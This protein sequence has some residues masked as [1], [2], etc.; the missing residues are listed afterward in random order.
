MKTEWDYTSLAS[1]YDQ[2]ADYSSDAIDAILAL[3]TPDRSLP[4]ADI[5]AGTGKLTLQLARRGL[6]ILAVEPNDEMRRIGEANLKGW[7]VTWMEGTGE[8]TGLSSA[9]AS[10]CAFGSSFNVVDATASLGEAARILVASG[11]FCCLWNHRVLEDPVQSMVEELIRRSVPA[12][13]YGSRRADQT[14][15]IRACGLF[16]DPVLIERGFVHSTSVSDYV[17]GWRSHATLARQAGAG[18]EAV[19]EEI[20]RLLKDQATLLVP[21][22]TRAWCARLRPPAR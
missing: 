12:Y 16:E 3:A 5:G 8:R 10:L 15:V 4:V 7:P 2:R 18:F 11:W 9:S 19:V 21:Y 22:T 1:H 6:R 20:A 17:D 14:D 13:A